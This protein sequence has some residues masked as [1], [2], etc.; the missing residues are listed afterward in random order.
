LKLRVTII[1]YLSV[2][3]L[4]ACGEKP[5]APPD[6]AVALR[7]PDAYYG[8]WELAG[9]SGGM[10]GRGEEVP[11]GIL[12]VLTKDHVAERHVPGKPVSRCN[13]TVRRGKTIYDSEP[14]WFIEAAGIG[15]SGVITVTDG[16]EDLTISDNH[17]D[18]FSSHYRRVE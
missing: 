1:T 13:F 7:L 16:G 3:A 17:Y 5:S 11:E 6:E 14:G 18:G 10:D 8:T 15:L 9:S 2:F 4:A 12:L